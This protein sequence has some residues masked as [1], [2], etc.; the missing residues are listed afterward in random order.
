M[1]SRMQYC[2]NHVLPLTAMVAVECTNVGLNVLF[3]EATAKG[4]NRYIF[5]TYS[6]AVGTLLLLPLSFV[7]PSSRTVIP[8]LKFHLG[9]RIFL[10]GLILERVALRSSSGQAKIIGTI[11]SISGALLVVL[12]K[13]PKV[14]VQW[15]L[16]SSEPNWVI[17][18]ILLATAYLLFSIWYIVQTQVLEIYPTELIVALFYNLCGAIISVPVSLITQP[19]LSSWILRPSVA[20]IAVLYSGVFQSFS[21]LVVTWGL[22]LKGPV[23]IAIFSPVSIAIA[24]FMS[25]IFLGDSLHLGVF[26]SNMCIGIDYSSPTLASAISNLEPAFTF[27]LAVLFIIGAIIISMGFYAV[28]SGKAKEGGRDSSSSGKVHLLKV[29]DIVE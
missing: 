14:L 6:Y 3:K 15:P 28:I 17:S 12:Y 4:M 29:E 18:G 24:A 25:A 9:S 7:F 8:S 27:I 1:S 22:H 11:A 13:A 5:I 2:Y 16:E 20:V 23:Y 26:S 10:L 19:K 21:S